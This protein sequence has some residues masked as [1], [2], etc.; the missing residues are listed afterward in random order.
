VDYQKEGRVFSL[1]SKRRKVNFREEE[2]FNTSAATS[3]MTGGKGNVQAHRKGGG[4]GGGGKSG[5][6]YA[7]CG[8]RRGKRA[9]NRQTPL[10]AYPPFSYGRREGSLY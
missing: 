4:G 9:S 2:A 3:T 1:V 8:D 5:P 10:S 6:K 7:S